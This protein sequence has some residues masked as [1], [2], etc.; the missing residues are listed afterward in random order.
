MWA[1]W[2]PGCKLLLPPPAVRPGGRCERLE[3]THL[4]EGSRRTISSA[5]KES[6]EQAWGANLGR[7]KNEKNVSSLGGSAGGTAT[8]LVPCLW[9]C[10]AKGPA[11]ASIYPEHSPPLLSSCTRLLA[12]L[13]SLLGPLTVTQSHR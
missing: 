6:E 9:W 4:R 2:H 12:N 8:V 11:G 13:A 10:V 5:A 1:P 7:P 3:G